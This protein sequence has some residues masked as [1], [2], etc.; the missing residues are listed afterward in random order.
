VSLFLFFH[1][2][3][4]LIYY[5]FLHFNVLYI[6]SRLIERMPLVRILSSLIGRHVK[7]QKVKNV[8]ELQN[9]SIRVSP[10]NPIKNFKISHH[11]FQKKKKEK[12]FA[13]I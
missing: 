9:V 5:E 2:F 10:L 6:F 7:K 8:P 13:K 4:L 11:F 1:V 3:S 12:K